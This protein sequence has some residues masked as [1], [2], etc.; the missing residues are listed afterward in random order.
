MVL[1][2]MWT[3]PLLPGLAANLVVVPNRCF[4]TI[5]VALSHGNGTTQLQPPHID[6]HCAFQETLVRG[7]GA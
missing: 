3:Q 7:G 4:N 6:K 1:R 5:M 2:G